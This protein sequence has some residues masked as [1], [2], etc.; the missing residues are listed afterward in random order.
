MHCLVH[1][2]QSWIKGYVR[3]AVTQSMICAWALIL[4]HGRDK[5]VCQVGIFFPVQISLSHVLRAFTSRVRVQVSHLTEVCWE[6]LLCPKGSED[7]CDHYPHPV[8][9]LIWSFALPWS[10]SAM[11]P[12]WISLQ[13]SWKFH[14]LVHG[15]SV[16]WTSLLL[17]F[18]ELTEVNKN[19]PI[20][21]NRCSYLNYFERKLFHRYR[22]VVRERELHF[23]LPLHPF[24]L[25][26]SRETAL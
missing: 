17:A 5:S 23:S 7:C 14:D 16:S 11:C 22:P 8:L 3:R 2:V 13:S 20:P 26:R 15:Y 24:I 18:T 4:F 25:S 21:G 9:Q 6:L 12:T 10:Y 19:I 1:C